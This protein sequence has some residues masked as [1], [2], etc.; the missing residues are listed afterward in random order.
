MNTAE[1]RGRHSARQLSPR[2]PSQTGRDASAIPTEFGPPAFLCADKAGSI[3]GKISR[4]TAARSPGTSPFITTKNKG[5]PMESVWVRQTGRGDATFWFMAICRR[6]SPTRR[7]SARQAQEASGVN[8][9]D[10]LSRAGSY[11][12][13]R[14]NIRA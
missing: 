12:P 10:T 2:A 11:A 9:S 8:P 6:R 5:Q 4:S 3:T 7:R 13:G 14:W 1:K